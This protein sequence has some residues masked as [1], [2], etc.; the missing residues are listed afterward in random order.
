MRHTI[1]TALGV[2]V[3]IAEFTTSV[4]AQPK[5]SSNPETGQFTLSGNSLVGLESRTVEDDFNNFFLEDSSTTQLNT[6]R[7]NNDLINRNGVVW[8]LSEN[9]QV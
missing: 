6:S 7:N 1:L 9:L 5:V 8:P 4:Q 2:L 3:A